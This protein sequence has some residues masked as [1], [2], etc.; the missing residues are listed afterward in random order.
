MTQIPQNLKDNKHLAY[1]FSLE[2]IFICE[3]KA[4]I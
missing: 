4:N 3:K 2:N 1:E